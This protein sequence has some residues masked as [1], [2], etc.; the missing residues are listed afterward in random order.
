[1]LAREPESFWQEKFDSRCYSTTSF[2]ENI[3]VAGTSYQMLEV[4]SFCYQERAVVLIKQVYNVHV[5]FCTFI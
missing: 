2:R 4:L 1:M 5:F 3:L